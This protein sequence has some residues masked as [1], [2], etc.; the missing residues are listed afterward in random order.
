MR[1]TTAIRFMCL[2]N[3]IDILNYLD[4]LDGC[5]LPGKS[6]F[7]FNFLGDLLKCCGIE[8]SMEKATPPSTKVVFIGI[9]FDADNLTISI[10]EHRLSEIIDSVTVWLDKCSCS[11]KELQ[12]LLGKLNYVSQCVRPGR[13]FVSR[14]LNWLREISDVDTVSIPEDFK[15]DLLWWKT[16]LPMYKGISM[17]LSDEWA[18]VDRLLA[19][20]ACLTGCG[21]WMNGRFFHTSFPK[22]ILDQNLHINL[23]ELLTIMVA[24]KL[25]GS[26]FSSKKILINCDNLVS[27]RVLNT[28][29][30]RNTFLQSCLREICFIAAVKNFDV[31]AKHITGCENRIPDLLSRWDFN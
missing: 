14:L 3:D 23:C 10:D 11:K 29:A 30:T 16:F 19:V 9:L 27:V 26:Y 12:S 7:A 31:K 15:L 24:L 4:D 25:W 6:P 20:V 22:F 17:M 13:L 21:G 28:G 8:E 2:K 18:S 1:T 5:E